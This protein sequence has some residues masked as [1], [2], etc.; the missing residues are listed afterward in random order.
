[1]VPLLRIGL[2][3]SHSYSFYRDILHGIR[4]YAE[5][6]PD[7]R[8]VAVTEEGR[9]LK[10]RG[11][12]RPHGLIA[13]INT[14]P[15]AQAMQTWH[16]PLVNVSAVL[17]N[18]P[19]PRVAVDNDR[20]GRMAARHLL[21][22]RLRSFAFV[23]H[24]EH[25]YSLE[26]EAAFR[27]ELRAAG[28]GLTSYHAK[29]SRPFEPNRWFWYLDRRIESW[30]LKLPKPV[31]ILAAADSWGMEL[32]EVCHQLSLR[33]P[34]DVAVVG[35]D[36][37]DL[38]TV[39][40]RPTLSSVA[41][42]SRQIGYEAAA[43]LDQLLAGKRPAKDPVLLPPTHVHVRRSSDVLAINN[44]DVIAAVRFIKERAHLPLGVDDVLRE[45]PLSRRSL[46]RQFRECLGC[47]IAEEIRRVHV[48]RGQRLLLETDSSLPLIA[49]QSGFTSARQMMD[50]F[51]RDVGLSPHEFRKQYYQQ[52]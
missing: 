15:I 34:E 21:E 18:L 29:K 50:V 32:T 37:D 48:E 14:L 11:S 31:G 25:L 7:W 24:G 51:R 40:A 2:L 39:F 10:W 49:E 22:R 16:R 23:G 42:P 26:R 52:D 41:L 28:I 9:R 12:D 6:H 3:V 4:A 46:E 35:V 45:I 44:Q 19:W 36:N 5:V 47:G 33:I 13:S 1:M 8:F 17:P 30:L 20:I 38:Y 43:L 27:A